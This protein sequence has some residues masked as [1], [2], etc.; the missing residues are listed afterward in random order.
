MPGLC[1]L[2]NPV[3]IFFIYIGF[4]VFLDWLF[5]FLFKGS[6]LSAFLFSSWY[7][8]KFCVCSFSM[9]LHISASIAHMLGKCW[10]PELLHAYCQSFKSIQSSFVFWYLLVILI[11]IYVVIKI[12]IPTHILCTF[13]HPFILFKSLFSHFLIFN[14]VLLVLYLMIFMYFICEILPHTQFSIIFFHVVAKEYYFN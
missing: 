4:G 7:R 9:L 13:C 2:P 10:S 12:M 5:T 8:Q 3:I 14:F 1:L 11:C 6:W